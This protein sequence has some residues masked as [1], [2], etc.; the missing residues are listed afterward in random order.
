MNPLGLE[1]ALR[2]RDTLERLPV[3]VS[4]LLT[5]TVCVF[6]VSGQRAPLSHPVHGIP[7]GLAQVLSVPETIRFS[8]ATVGKLSPD[9]RSVSHLRSSMNPGQ[10]TR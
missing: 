1:C 3:L 7:P 6:R 8:H 10:Q 4:T 9:L 2:F 5:P